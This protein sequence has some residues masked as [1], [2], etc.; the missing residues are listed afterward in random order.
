MIFD[1]LAAL[2]HHLAL[3][4]PASPN[5]IVLEEYQILHLSI[6]LHID[7]QLSILFRHELRSIDSN[8]LP[9]RSIT[10]THLL[11]PELHLDL[12]STVDA[13][14]TDVDIVAGG[15]VRWDD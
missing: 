15:D 13:D 14:V 3:H 10:L 6:L 11:D 12:L 9:Q 4:L 2:I 1:I 8:N 7:R 5:I